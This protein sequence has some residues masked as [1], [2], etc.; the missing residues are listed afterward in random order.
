[1]ILFHFFSLSHGIFAGSQ[2]S[3]AIEEEI[4]DL[5]NS[6]SDLNIS[7]DADAERDSEDEGRIE[8]QCPDCE[9]LCTDLEQ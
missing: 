7:T 8:F 3:G 6:K 1:M 4:N 2:H 9:R 5:H